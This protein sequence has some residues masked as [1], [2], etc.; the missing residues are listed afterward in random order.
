[1]ADYPAWVCAD[2]GEKWGRRECREATWHPDDCGIC[3]QHTFV[4][5]PRDFGHLRHGWQ[6]AQRKDKEGEA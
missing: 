4:T 6:A 3:G 1:M 2:C 5:E